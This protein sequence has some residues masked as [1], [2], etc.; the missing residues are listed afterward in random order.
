MAGPRLT[1]II[2]EPNK[3]IYGP[4]NTYGDTFSGINTKSLA[5]LKRPPAK[6]PI[7]IPPPDPNYV[8]DSY[9]SYGFSLIDAPD[10][11][12]TPIPLLLNPLSGYVLEDYIGREF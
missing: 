8:L 10:Y 6:T 4:G 7:Y 9:Y 11:D 12:Y 1:K 2:F 5:A 3:S